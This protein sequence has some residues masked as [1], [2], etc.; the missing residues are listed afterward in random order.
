MASQDVL[1]RLEQ[2]ERDVADLKTRMTNAATGPHRS[3]R[4]GPQVWPPP[5][6]S[7]VF[8]PPPAPPPPPRSAPRR[9]LKVPEGFLDPGRLLPGS[10]ESSVLGTWFARVGAIALLIGAAFG[11]KYAIDEGVIGPTARVLL[12][13]AAGV[14]GVAWG[15]GAR[16]R[17]WAGFAQAIS[18]AG[19]GLLYMS[20]L[21]ALL[22]YDLVPAGVALALLTG[23]AA[24]SGSLSLRHDSLAL[25][26]LAGIAG[27]LNAGLIAVDTGDA[28][29]LF[30]YVLVIDLGVLGLAYF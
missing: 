22:L 28:V 21:S 2:L 10:L 3:S 23:V 18:A 6:P 9:G 25:A 1:R 24:L 16:R 15:E 29:A 4:P 12:G 20:I 19:I 5:P 26:V 11:F 7:H 14:A 30:S 8:P 17:A 27:F 13:V